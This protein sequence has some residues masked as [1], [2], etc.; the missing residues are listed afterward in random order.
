MIKANKAKPTASELDIQ[1]DDIGVIASYFGRVGD[2][3]RRRIEER[4]ESAQNNESYYRERVEHYLHEV[5][6]AE[7]SVES[8]ERELSD[9]EHELAHL[10]PAREI[11]R[12]EIRADLKKALALSFVQSIAVERMDDHV[13]IV[14]TTREGSLSTNLNRK[15]SR[16]EKWY[17]AKPYKIALPQYKI[18]IGTALHKS[19]TQNSDALGLA[20]AYPIADTANYLSWVYRYRHQPH[21]HWGTPSVRGEITAWRGICLGEFEHEVSKA[22]RSS[23]ADALVAVSIYLQTSGATSAYVHKREEWALWLGKKEYNTAIVPSEKEVAT[24]VEEDEGRWCDCRQNADDDCE[25][26]DDCECSCHN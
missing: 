15:F 20:L 16:A 13:F 5:K 21:P 7:Q 3:D 12:D 9:I 23:I 26:G 24:L 2:T 14:A 19:I 25:N 11:S 10:P 22:V 4:R 8:S 1:P 18:R 6:D 17:R